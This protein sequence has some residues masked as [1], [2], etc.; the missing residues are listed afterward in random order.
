MLTFPFPAPF[1]SS[2]SVAFSGSRPTKRPVSLTKWLRLI[3]WVCFIVTIL[4]IRS[5]AQYKGDHIPGFLGLDSGTQAPPGLYV[6]NVVWVYPTS[7]IKDNNGHSVNLPGSLT[8]TAELILLNGVTNYKLFGANV[9]GSAA[10]PFIKNRI[11]L[12]SLNVNTGFAFTDMFISAQLGWHLKGA[13]ITAG[14][15]LYIPTGKFSSGGTDNTGLGMWGNELT[16]GSTVY[17]DQK[18]TWT[19]AA[20]FG[21]EFHSDKSGTNINP[22]DLGTVEGGLGKTFYKKV[23]GPIPMIMNVGLAGYSQFKVTGDSGSDIP[24]VLRGYKDRVF[25]LGPEFNM[26]IPKP[27]LTLLARYEPEFGARN[28][29]QGQTIVFSIA[30]VA[31]SLAKRQP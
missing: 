27:R 13:D 11:Q 1:P 29:S 30:W 10:F 14:Y 17:L 9:G 4:P 7:T 12:N 31:K 5:E 21:L 6:G 15:N 3:P 8:S 23:S 16:V 19:A 18:R 20:N 25:A 24:P 26:Y 28:R 2:E 22:G